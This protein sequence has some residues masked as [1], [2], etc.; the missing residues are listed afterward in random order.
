MRLEE[1]SDFNLG[2]NTADGGCIV[3]KGDSIVL[4]RQPDADGLRDLFDRF[5]AKLKTCMFGLFCE[6]REDVIRKYGLLEENK[7]QRKL[8]YGLIVQKNGQFTNLT[9]VA[10]MS[11]LADLGK[12]PATDSKG[13][14]RERM[15]LR[16]GNASATVLALT[17]DE[18]YSLIRSV[19]DRHDI[20]DYLQNQKTFRIG[21][22]V[23]R[24]M[25]GALDP[26]T[27]DGFMIELA[28]AFEK[29]CF[30]PEVRGQ[31]KRVRRR[32]PTIFAPLWFAMFLASE[33]VWLLP[34]RL[35]P[36]AR[37]LAPFRLQPIAIWMSVPQHT[38]PFATQVMEFGRLRER[39]LVFNAFIS[40]AVSSDMWSTNRFC[41]Y[42]LTVLKD[43][44]AAREGHASR[45]INCNHYYFRLAESFNVHVADRPDFHVF[46]LSRRNAVGHSFRW[47]DD[48]TPRN[49]MVVSQLIGRP[50]ATVPNFVR[51]WAHRLDELLP[52]FEVKYP[53]HTVVI[54][55]AWLAYLLTLSPKTAP[56]SFRE[57][58]RETHAEPFLAFIEQGFSSY[59]SR[60]VAKTIN[61]L[62][63]CWIFVARR[64][65]FLHEL[66]NPFDLDIQEKSKTPDPS[67]R[68]AMPFEVWS[69]LTKLNYQ[70]DYAFARGFDKYWRRV[71]DPK[72][73]KKKTVFWGCEARI[74]D[75]IFCGGYRLMDARHADSGEGD[76]Y[77]LNLETVEYA[78]N[79][80]PT[81]ERG[82]QSGFLQRV[83]LDNPPRYVVAGWRIQDKSNKPK[84]VPHVEMRLARMIQ[85]FA[86]L[87]TR[88]NP[89]TKAVPF[90]NRS[91]RHPAQNLKAFP[92]GFLLFRDIG[93]TEKFF[94][95]SAER[96]RDY[97]KAFCE[98]A[99]P[100]LDERLG[101]YFP[102]FLDGKLR[103]AIH[104]LRTT[105]VTG[106]VRAGHP[107]EVAQ[108][109]VGHAN[110]Q[111]TAH[112]VADQ[113]GLAH[114]VAAQRAAEREERANLTDRQL[115]EEVVAADYRL[116]GAEGYSGLDMATALL[117]K[118]RP[119]L[120]TRF[121]HGICPAGDCDK[122]K[123]WRHRA[124][125]RCPFRVTGP[126]YVE[127]CADQVN[128]LLF[129]FLDSLQ[130]ERELN[131]AMAQVELRGATSSER[132][133]V[134]KEQ[135][136]RAHLLD[137]ILEEIKVHQGLLHLIRRLAAM[138]VGG[139]NRIL[140]SPSPSFDERTTSF[141]LRP[142]HELQLLHGIVGGE[143]H[144]GT[145]F[146]TPSLAK[147]RYKDLTRTIARSA[148]LGRYM[149][150]LDAAKEQEFRRVVADAIVPGAKADDL[151]RLVEGVFDEDAFPNL[152]PTVQ[153]YM[154]KHPELTHG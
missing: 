59:E 91:S 135:E 67:D 154:Q 85:E 44:I 79:T 7:K 84:L 33:G 66:D 78:E 4:L 77:T 60:R 31:G 151:I 71:T 114:E 141:S 120:I 21:F 70:D 80:L 65:R 14:T 74:L 118:K 37:Y 107:L 133:L 144:P 54:L 89:V 87:Q 1:P 30:N 136:F 134:R 11:G 17:V 40:T 24:E 123:V 26:S 76:E 153:T 45:G 34:M 102:L 96:C 99:Q 92:H 39:S 137:D 25:I 139:A 27:V 82:R 131:T 29:A 62:K 13:K 43:W 53:Q 128:I 149:Y 116:E 52:S 119:S 147:E 38:M 97:F 127:G 32:P 112:Y 55:N 72:T 8:P 23:L 16:A 98:W 19:I 6:T 125:S 152:L 108:V 46:H 90:L 124:C 5:E 86:A 145:V 138:N 69:I 51:E 126:R 18:Q 146:S 63:K 94:A 143:L 117:L 88:Y 58:D 3:N 132:N 100:I 111:M 95:I 130:R 93:D 81:A 148:G 9:Q 42:P 47:C 75:M 35:F 61:T 140:V 115:L 56:R 105:T 41:P 36:E 57:I 83:W 50:V 20:D 104:D 2:T 28:N 103:F 49:T 48:P 129:E 113:I 110:K 10:V 122:A 142:A 12:I 64:E 22:K 73:R 121:E 68:E 109:L 15:A 106:I 150:H 101:Y